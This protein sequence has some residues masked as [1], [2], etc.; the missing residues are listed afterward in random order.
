MDKLFEERRAL[1]HKQ[2]QMIREKIEI[3]KPILNDERQKTGESILEHH[4]SVMK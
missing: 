3:G 1:L 4:E 2:N